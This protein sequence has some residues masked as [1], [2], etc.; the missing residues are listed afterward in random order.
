VVQPHCSPSAVAHYSMLTRQAILAIMQALIHVSARVP[1]LFAVCV[2]SWRRCTP[3]LPSH[4]L[5]SRRCIKAIL[6]APSQCNGSTTVTHARAL[7]RQVPS[8]L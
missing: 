3:F 4:H 8:L 5:T 1:S 2:A 7:Q 6:I